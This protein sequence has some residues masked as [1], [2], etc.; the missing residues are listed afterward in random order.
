V[1]VDKDHEMVLVYIA[2]GVGVALLLWGAFSFNALVT[3]HNR[4][5]ESWSG[6]DVQLK[7]RHDLVPNLMET[8]RAYAEHERVV[9]RALTEAR[10]TAVGS[11]GRRGRQ[12]AEFELSEAIADARALA[13]R[14][15]EMRAS[16]GFKRLQS[17]LAEVEGEIQYGR[18]IYNSNV[19]LFNARVRGFPGSLV[20]RLGGFRKM[21]Y[22][23]LNPV[24]RSAGAGADAGGESEAAAA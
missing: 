4:V 20:R 22:F 9:M 2:A 5:N 19:M 18:R 3:A 17:Q 1:G 7:R 14:Y 6:V 21:G 24:W 12:A 10:E 8:V 16:E 13:E 15:P 23:E 11:S